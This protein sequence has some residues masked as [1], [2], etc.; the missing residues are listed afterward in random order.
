MAPDIIVSASHCASPD[1]TTVVVGVF[2]LS[3]LS[4]GNVETFGIKKM[5]LHPDYSDVTLEHDVLVI[6][7]DGAITVTDPVRINAD[8][9]VPSPS[10]ILTNVGWGATSDDGYEYPDLLQ[11]VDLFYVP[12][13][14]CKR[15]ADNDGFS[16]GTILFDDMMCATDEG[17]SSCFGDSGGPLIL[18]GASPSDDVQVGVVS[19]GPS[20]AGPIPGIYHRLSYSYDWIESLV[21]TR[22]A[23]PPEYFNCY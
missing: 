5:Y 11:E 8:Y 10:N 2:D 21:C 15:I 13:R 1:V 17:K 3:D 18:L 20:C 16:L 9:S 7:L 19:W 12:N 6:K 22:S 4:S 14:L 23:S